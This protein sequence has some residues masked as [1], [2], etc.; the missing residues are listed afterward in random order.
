MRE[1][2][3][4]EV[5]FGMND[6]EFFVNEAID[7]KNEETSL[8]DFINLTKPKRKWS[9]INPGFMIGVAHCYLGALFESNFKIDFQNIDFTS[10]KVIR[11]GAKRRFNENKD[12]IRALR[13]AIAHHNYKVYE[14]LSIINDSRFSIQFIDGNPRIKD[15]FVEFSMS[16]IDFFNFISECGV[17]LY[18]MSNKN[19][20][21]M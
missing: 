15:D 16:M 1:I 18:A 13:N 19:K 6:T 14:E 7:E 11:I 4:Y 17:I 3:K 20:D 5:L 21:R 8:K 9:V 2:N 10:L 12:K